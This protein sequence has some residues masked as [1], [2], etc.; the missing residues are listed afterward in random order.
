MASAPVHLAVASQT[1]PAVQPTS[2]SRAG[3]GGE[4]TNPEAAS[5]QALHASPPA[6]A[7]ASWRVIEN[8]GTEQIDESSDNMQWW[9]H[10]FALGSEGRDFHISFIIHYRLFFSPRKKDVSFESIM[11]V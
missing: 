2:A 5:G 1:R 9:S 4:Q 8:H 3:Q 7:R 6:H 11:H 10:H